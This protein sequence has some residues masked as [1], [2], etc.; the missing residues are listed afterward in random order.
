MS[1]IFH[2]NKCICIYIFQLSMLQANCNLS[3]CIEKTKVPLREALAFENTHTKLINSQRCCSNYQNVKCQESTLSCSFDRT[4]S[5]N[6]E[7]TCPFAKITL[8]SYN[9]QF[10]SRVALVLHCRDRVNSLYVT[11]MSEV[12]NSLFWTEWIKAESSAM[13]NCL[14]EDPSH[15]A[16]RL[17]R[18]IS[19]GRGICY[20]FTIE[21][22]LEHS[23]F[24]GAFVY[25]CLLQPL[26]PEQAIW[27]KD[28]P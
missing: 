19:L 17:P 14:W 8:E 11:K 7:R 1:A 10:F 16:Y 5:R 27:P 4:K 28:T 2:L 21:V 20:N 23:D 15:D 9:F 3:G 13:D 6:I 12:S 22:F 26:T 25:V 18:S 24:A